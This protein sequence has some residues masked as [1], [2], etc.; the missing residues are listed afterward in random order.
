MTRARRVPT[1]LHLCLI[2]LIVLMSVSTFAQSAPPAEKQAAKPADAKPAAAAQKPAEAKPVDAKADQKPADAKAEQKPADAKPAAP[3][4]APETK[5]LQDASR[6]TDV[7]KQIE[8]FKKSSRTS[9][10]PV[11]PIRPRT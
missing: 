2:V 4:V 5:A 3:P 6:L 8:A 11:R 7:D 1:W 10:R 9:R